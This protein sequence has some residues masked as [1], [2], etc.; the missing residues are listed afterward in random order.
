MSVPTPE[1]EPDTSNPRGFGESQWLVDFHDRLLKRANVRVA[2]ARPQAWLDTARVCAQER[3]RDEALRWLESTFD[4]EHPEVL[5]KDPR[6]AWFLPLWRAAAMRLDIA[7]GVV[8]TLRAPSEVVGSKERYYSTHVSPVSRTAAWVNHMLH[9]ERATRDMSRAMIRYTDLLDDWTRPIYRLGETFGLTAVR[10][11]TAR[12][13]RRIHDL[14]DPDLHRVHTTWDDLEV[15]KSLRVIV[16]ETWRQ[17]NHLADPDGDS[18]GVREALDQLRS[19][20]TQLYGDAEAIAESSALA[21]RRKKQPTPP[22][23]DRTEQA[24]PPSAPVAVPEPAGPRPSR[25]WL[26]LRGHRAR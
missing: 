10:S 21:A 15:P 23:P 5:L 19:E 14:I 18:A 25:N 8:M 1:V 3:S 13:L 26:G 7:P 11:A 4:A 2:D 22:Q 12:D 24:P 16:D 6:L 20:Y 17:L 9:T